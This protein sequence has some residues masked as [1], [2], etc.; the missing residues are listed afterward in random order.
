[1]EPTVRMM[2][3]G[4]EIFQPAFPVDNQTS[5]KY[6]LEWSETILTK[7]TMRKRWTEFSTDGAGG[8]ELTK[9]GKTG[10]STWEPLKLA[11]QILC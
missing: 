8:R 6:G 1:M 4:D 9:I 7:K 2:V 5:H 3:A 10:P 11:R